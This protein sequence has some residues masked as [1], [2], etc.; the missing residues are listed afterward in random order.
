MGGKA[1]ILLFAVG[2]D[3]MHELRQDDFHNCLDFDGIL[4]VQFGTQLLHGHL[5]IRGCSLR[6]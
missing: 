3:F 2:E 4:L 5:Q 6:T 1:H